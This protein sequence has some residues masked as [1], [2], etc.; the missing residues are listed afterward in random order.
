MRSETLPS[1]IKRVNKIVFPSTV[2][3]GKYSGSFVLIPGPILIGLKS[4]GLFKASCANTQFERSSFAEASNSGLALRLRRKMSGVFYSFRIISGCL[5]HSCQIE[6]GKSRR[7][8][9]WINTNCGF[10]MFNRFWIIIQV[11]I[12]FSTHNMRLPKN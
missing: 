6:K 5:L 1:S 7:R 8:V 12:E 11:L 4:K 9:I 10:Q 2:I 3:V